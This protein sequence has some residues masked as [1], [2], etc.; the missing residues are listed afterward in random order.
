M[1]PLSRLLLIAASLAVP[2]ATQSAVAGEPGPAQ[3]VNL[4]SLATDGPA[5]LGS[6]AGEKLVAVDGSTLAPAP[7][8]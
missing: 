7:T 8:S 3:A 6:M 1:N 5:W 2:L 4:S